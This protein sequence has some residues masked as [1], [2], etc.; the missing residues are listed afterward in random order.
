MREPRE[1]TSGETPA[2]AAARAAGRKRY[3]AGKAFARIAHFEK[4]RGLALTRMEDDRVSTS[5]APTKAAPRGK[6]GKGRP[7]ARPRTA[8]L[9]YAA[10]FRA[11]ARLAP[12]FEDAAGIPVW[13]ELG[14]TDIPHGQTYGE[15]GND[16]PPVSGR[17][18]GIL[19]DPADRRR[20]V[21]CSAG[22]G[23]WGSLDAGSRWT[24]LTDDQ[25][26]L[27]M[28]AIA[29]APGAP[30]IVY[31][32]TGE[33]DTRSPLGIGLLRSS[34]G[35]WTWT[36]ARADALSGTG[37][38]DVA[39]DPDDPYHLWVG[40]VAGLFESRD[41]GS[42]F[43]AVRTGL[44]WDVSIHPSSPREL[45]VATEAG[46]LR[47]ANGGAAWSSV[48]L[49]GGPA[50][51]RFSRMEVCHAPSGAAIAY[52]AAAVG[53]RAYLW[54]RSAAAG[55]F[56]PEAV[57]SGMNVSQAW[58]DWCFAV[59]PADPDT[60]Y[61]GAIELYRGR[62]AS[63]AFQWEN[64][65]SRNVG[66]SIHPD[67]H[68]LAFDPSDPAMLYVC[69]D[70]G[71]F[72]SPDGGT[73]WESL[74]PGLGIT[75]FEFLAQLEGQ[76]QWII[77]GTQDNGTL[78]HAGGGRWDQ[79]ALG[80]GG[81]CGASESGAPVCYHSYYDMWIER[82]PAAGPNAFRWEDVSP[83]TFEG[84]AALFYPPME[85]QGT[86][87]VKAGQ[88]V[89][90]SADSGT[91]WNE[92]PLPPVAGSDV[93]VASALNIVDATTILVGTVSGNLYRITRGG[94]G[95]GAASVET[96]RSP[97]G[98]F[99]S[100]IVAT[101]ASGSTI[102]VSCS[103]V[104]GPHVLRSTN[105]GRKWSDRTGNLPDIP[106]NAI[107]V[108]PQRPT[109]LFAATDDGVYETSNGGTRWA[110]FSNGLPNVVVGDLILHQGRRLLRAGTRNRGAWEV[111]I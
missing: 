8:R 92:V 108:D 5:P 93:D 43:R 16:R 81:D 101:G 77:G 30:N 62:R 78:S 72:R 19:V 7:K 89:F 20:L 79:V 2:R 73:R 28:G 99:L 38:Y 3:P 42:T 88:S 55:G 35:G 46:L 61:W 14:P 109:R 25:P 71:L 11:K 86:L 24:P 41:G 50:G 75:E 85:V 100:D 45:L 52:V 74:N 1:A 48:P 102:W 111:A 60:V 9:P 23:L 65:S 69:N 26:T 91:S 70:G 29:A 76:H 32:G 33:G 90:V 64:V 95:W 105:G 96:L 97:R 53:G 47:S 49:P 31:A 63:G 6:G 106:V 22:G 94:G 12:A 39:V 13:R 10:A 51:G 83:P 87:V 98:A 44:T 67:Q 59:S 68:H 56:A 80:D 66:D 82:A 57:P 104:G 4:Q 58:Y 17:C 103:A 18:V 107:V 27:S 15:G 21:L 54:R 36:H 37:V 110:D 40:A 84:Y 34:D